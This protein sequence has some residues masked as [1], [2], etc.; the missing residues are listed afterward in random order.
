M[1]L[2]LLIYLFLFKQE[3]DNHIDSG[4]VFAKLAQDL[5]AAG[6]ACQMLPLLPEMYQPPTLQCSSSTLPLLHIFSS[7]IYPERGGRTVKA[8]RQSELT[9]NFLPEATISV[10][11]MGGP[12][13]YMFICHST[14]CMHALQTHYNIRMHFNQ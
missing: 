1:L 9:T 13:L 5:L 11:L 7:S 3:F 14:Q 4:C 6:T 2:G 8:S 12:A 10:G